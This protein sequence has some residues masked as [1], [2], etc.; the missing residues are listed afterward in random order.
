MVR[1]TI[2]KPLVQ[3]LFTSKPW[4]CTVGE[5]HIIYVVNGMLMKLVHGLLT[6]SSSCAEKT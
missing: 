1:W 2:F 4:R 5:M 3:K 6:H